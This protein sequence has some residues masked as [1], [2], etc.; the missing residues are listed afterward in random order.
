MVKRPPD[1]ELPVNTVVV[2][3]NWLESIAARLDPP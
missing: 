1:A 3:Q 2:V